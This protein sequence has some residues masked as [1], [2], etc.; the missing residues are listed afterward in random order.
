MKNTSTGITNKPPLPGLGNNSN[1]S[2]STTSVMKAAT[3]ALSHQNSTTNGSK[4]I[5]F[6]SKV[7]YSNEDKENTGIISATAKATTK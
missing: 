6:S 4:N 7:I 5:Q 2:A 1:P 3:S